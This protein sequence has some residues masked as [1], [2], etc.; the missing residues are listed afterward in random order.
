MNIDWQPY[1]LMLIPAI[2][3]RKGAPLMERNPAPPVEKKPWMTIHRWN[4]EAISQEAKDI[5]AGIAVEYQE[6]TLKTVKL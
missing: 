1:M 4:G 2:L 3:G 5:D 6:V